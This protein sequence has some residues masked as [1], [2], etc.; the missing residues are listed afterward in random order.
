MHFEIPHRRIDTNSRSKIEQSAI[1][2]HQ[3]TFLLIPETISVRSDE[4]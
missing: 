2:F 1:D 4:K 3:P